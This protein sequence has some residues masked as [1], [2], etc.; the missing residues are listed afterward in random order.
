MPQQLDLTATAN[1]SQSISSSCRCSISGMPL[2]AA[3]LI[4]TASHILSPRFSSSASSC[5]AAL[6]YG[7]PGSGNSTSHMFSAIFFRYNFSGKSTLV[8]NIAQQLGVALR[9][10]DCFTFASDIP[11]SVSLAFLCIFFLTR[12]PSLHPI[13]S[14]LRASLKCA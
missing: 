1:S 10:I 14:I 6:V 2:P 3:A 11:V 8:A 7:P 4:S 12:C 5:I 13:V 9:R